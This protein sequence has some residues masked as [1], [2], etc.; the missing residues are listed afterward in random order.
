MS[1]EKKSH[2]LSLIAIKFYV[3]FSV[4]D[5]IDLRETKGRKIVSKQ[6]Y[7]F[8]GLQQSKQTLNMKGQDINEI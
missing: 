7:I 1:L 5:K 2:L 3:S 6:L 8:L 4:T